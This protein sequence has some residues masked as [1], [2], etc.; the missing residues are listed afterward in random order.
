MPPSWAPNTSLV[1]KARRSMTVRVEPDSVSAVVVSS[2]V[3][4]LASVVV[5]VPVALVV[6]VALVPIDVNA[7]SDSFLREVQAR[8]GKG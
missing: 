3:V 6:V 1:R 8:R 2:I 4:V 5:L 7:T